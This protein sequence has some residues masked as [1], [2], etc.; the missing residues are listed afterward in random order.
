MRTSRP[1]RV[2]AKPHHSSTASATPM[3]TSALS[4]SAE[5]TTVLSLQK[6]SGIAG[7]CGACGW[8]SGLPR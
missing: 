4:C 2:R 1:A 3:G 5:R 6:P 7:I 8:M